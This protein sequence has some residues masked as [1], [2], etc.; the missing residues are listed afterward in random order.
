M[1]IVRKKKESS[2]N[3]LAPLYTT[4]LPQTLDDVT[5]LPTRNAAVS[6]ATF[7][8]RNVPGHHDNEDRPFWGKTAYKKGD[9]TAYVGGVCD[10]HDTAIAS[11]F[12][13][14]TLPGLLF[15]RLLEKP[16]L[17]KT[18]LAT[19]ES[20]ETDLTKTGTTSGSCVIA[21]L[22]LGQFILNLNLGDCR[23]AYIPLTPT[24][25][26]PSCGKV[27]WLSRDAKA[28]SPHER[29]RIQAAGGTIIDGRTAGVLEP[30]RTIG[31]ADVKQRV[32]PGV[33]SIIPENRICDI[34][35]TG[36]DPATDTSQKEGG[37]AVIVTGTDGIWD[38]V[39]ASDLQNVV[40]S[41][42][43]DLR[44]IQEDMSAA[45][46]K[47]KQVETSFKTEPLERLSK[48]IVQLAVGKGSTD[49][50]TCEIIMVMAPGKGE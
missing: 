18:V 21:N 26:T 9:Y 28:S 43:G 25:Q 1:P 49:D 10:G 15:K 19:F 44:K 5:G 14:D 7:T 2:G 23:S 6:R 8:Q 20:L 3:L 40:G 33:I 45:I 24:S 35:S 41:M 4:Q 46:A 31:D 12:V 38:E 48:A 47:G 16:Q 29:Q 36:R 42:L 50:C 34:L 17:Q 27:L 22:I 30:S 37:C 11:T 32:P 39:L 13:A